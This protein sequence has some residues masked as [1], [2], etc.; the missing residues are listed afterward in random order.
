MIGCKQDHMF[1]Y[2]CLNKYHGNKPSIRCPS[3]NQEGMKKSNMRR[4]MFADRIIKNSKVKCALAYNS[5]NPKGCKWKGELNGL[6][7]HIQK[8]CPLFITKCNHCGQHKQRCKL[9]QH[10]RICPEKPL[11]CKLKCSL[12]F[13]LF[14]SFFFFVVFCA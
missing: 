4:S 7:K 10:D 6:S 12:V 8:D 1:C 14:F 2:Q 11:S 5:N 13:S 3:C 9:K